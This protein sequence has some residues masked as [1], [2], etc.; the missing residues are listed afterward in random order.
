V[1]D[2]DTLYPLR[3]RVELGT[4]LPAVLRKFPR[5][6]DFARAHLDEVFGEKNLA[7]AEV[8]Q[9]DNF[10]SG[11]FLSQPDG[12]YRFEA[13]PRAAQI[14]PIQGIVAADL[15]GDGLA[16]VCAVQNTDAAIP[17]YD[18]GVGIFLRGKGD[19]R[20]EA[21]APAQS[22]LLVPGNGRALAVA[23]FNADLCPDLFFTRQGGTT[24]FLASQAA[25]LRWLKIKLRDGKYNADAIGARVQLVFTHQKPRYYEI[26]CGGG[27]FSQSAPEI[28]VAVPPGSRL[29]EALVTWPDGHTSHHADAPE[30]GL[31]TIQNPGRP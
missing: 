26:G 25:G 20:F 1:Y 4:R 3:A 31:W 21:I 5:N 2:G 8:R 14:G 13:F 22:G 28:Y 12:S 6:D 18:G 17:R 10:S 27:W 19:G 23:D 11:V 24:G 29:T 30:H 15:D 9:A 16:D 7:A